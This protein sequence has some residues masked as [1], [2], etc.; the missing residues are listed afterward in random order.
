MKKVWVEYEDLAPGLRE[1]VDAV[2][3]PRSARAVPWLICANDSGE[4]FIGIQPVE[5]RPAEP[6]F[7][8]RHSMLARN[9]DPDGVMLDLEKRIWALEQRLG[10][11]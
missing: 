11:G 4:R 7:V 10:D 3:T 6:E 5:H 8:S 2:C 9:S 1:L